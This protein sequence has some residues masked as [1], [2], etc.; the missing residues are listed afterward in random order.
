MNS[1]IYS[2]I[3]KQNP[4]YYQDTFF[5]IGLGLLLLC[6]SA[7]LIP[8]RANN[9]IFRPRMDF[10]LGIYTIM[11]GYGIALLAKFKFRFGKL[12]QEYI[13][14]WASLATVSCFTLNQDV[15]VFEVLEDWAS[16]YTIGAIVCCIL[17]AFRSLFPKI[18]VYALYVGL[19]ASLLIFLYF[20]FYLLP[21]YPL[22][23][24]AFW[25]MG[26]SLHTFVPLGLSLQVFLIG[27]KAYK[28]QKSL[29]YAM[30][31]GFLVP[32]VCLITFVG[33]FA[34]KYNRISNISN[35][36]FVQT[37]LEPTD[38]KPV[39]V[40]V[41][42]RLDNDWF[43]EQA[44]KKDFFFVSQNWGRG[45]S[46]NFSDGFERRHNPVLVILDLVTTKHAL[47]EHESRKILEAIHDKRHHS[48]QRLWTGQNLHTKQIVTQIELHPEYRLSYTE[49]TFQIENIPDGNFRTETQEALYTFY[50]PEGGVV[51]SLSLWIN[52]KEEKGYLTSKSKAD[53]AYKTIV[54]RE[55]RDPA[56]VHWQEG[57][58]ITVR[59]FP[60]T[61]QQ[62]RQFKIG[63]TAPLKKIERGLVYQSIYFK[64]TKLDVTKEHIR[65]LN[66]DK[67]IQNASFFGKQGEH[68]SYEGDLKDSWELEVAEKP[69]K[70]TKFTFNNKSYEISA[71]KKALEKKRIESIYLDINALWEQEE[72]EA[73]LAATQGKKVYVLSPEPVQITPQN[74]K[75]LFDVLHKDHFSMF[76]FYKIHQIENVLC[77]GKTGNISPNINDVKKDA[78]G[79]NLRAFLIEQNKSIHYWN[80]SEE[81][82][83]YLKTLKEMRIV[84]LE[85]NTLEGFL[86]QL[87]N[88][89]LLVNQEDDKTV[90]LE[91]AQIKIT[92]QV[93]DSS[94]KVTSNVPDHLLR[95]FAY[96]D[97]MRKIG[98]DFFNE[99]HIR[100]DLLEQ[101]RT[102]YI[103]SPLSSLIVLETKQ[104]YERFDIKQSK[105][106]LENATL[107]NAGAVPEP[108]EWA[109]II[110]L[111]I[112][113]WYFY[114]NGFKL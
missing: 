85:H 101:A 47:D 7:L 110:V 57:N 19:G 87:K 71:Y 15:R 46:L 61:P 114:R 26:L 49:K 78:F 14:L 5:L 52:G 9:N 106:S 108:H 60:C 83:P 64:G 91:N 68:L 77:I 11:V 74:A 30:S 43:T 44:I 63:I 32:F 90:V 81:D 27:Y 80:L 95:L 97:L 70:T 109:L 94:Q 18:A 45:L 8:E 10:A 86:K 1:P 66:G 107:K 35:E 22:S 65:I 88:E 42:Q 28:R 112:S 79:K 12:P 84:L 31:G 36:Q 20:A 67:Y 16:I 111:V 56:L 34:I 75:N 39:W 104:D 62:K 33:V 2:K 76:A 38:D 72:Y 41:A 48:E 21:L 54:G 69:L 93:A 98:N 40:K 89:E 3:K 13:L 37:T 58:S 29:F 25:V 92:E 113:V 96:N 73:I 102:A 103:V 59:V 100:E 82:S 99:K 51:T 24:A 4:S 53:S 105:N 55:V 6:A 50:L 17:Y 23:L